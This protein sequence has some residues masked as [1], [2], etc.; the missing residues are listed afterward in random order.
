MHA[1]IA[2]TRPFGKT[3]HARPT[4]GPALVFGEFSGSHGLGRAAAY[5]LDALRARHTSLTAIDIGPYLA[6]SPASRLVLDG[7]IENVYFLSQPDTYGTICSLLQPSDIAQA[8][9]VGRMAWETPLFPR[10]WRF[11]ESMLHEVWAPSEFC[12]RTF[13]AALNVPVTVV[14]YAVTVPPDPG[15][16]MRARLGIPREAFVGLAMMD[17]RSCPERKNP[18]EHVRV[19]RQAHGDDANCVLIIKVRVSRHTRVVLDELREL[20]GPAGN[21]ILVSEDLSGAEIASLQR[22]ADLFLS[23]HR[24]E[25]FGL[26]ICE[27]LLLGKRVVATNWSANAEYGPSFPNYVGVPYRLTAYRDWMGHYEDGGFEWADP[28]TAIGTLLMPGPPP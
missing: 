23:L 12:A 22:A 17:I 1:R 13:T 8:Y 6:G 20:I 26:A 24:S 11:A 5:D 2:Q 21:I 7:G 10:A 16:D 18:W 4:D 3:A 25:G 27:A 9:R 28:S 19:W 15:I 14:P